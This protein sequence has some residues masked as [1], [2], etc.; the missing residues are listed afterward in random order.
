ME[1]KNLIYFVLILTVA[2]FLRF[3]LLTWNPPALNW[4][5]ISHGY[6]AYSIL[7]TGMDQWGQRLPILN[8]RAYGDYPT[9]LNIYLTIPFILIFGL[10]DFALRFPHALM[11]LLC[12]GLVYLF[13]YG[14]TKKQSVALFAAALVAIEPWYVFTSRFVLQSNLAVFFLIL[15][16]VLFIWREKN[17][18][19]LGISFLSLFLTLFAYHTTRIISPL[20]LVGALC[21]Y[22]KEIKNKLIYAASILFIILSI[23]ILINPNAT[24]RGNLLFILD[25]T[26]VNKIEQAR[27]TSKLPV[28]I[29]NL[30]YNR[31]VYFA[32]NFAKNYFSYFSP[33]FLFLDGG[34]QYQ[35][36]VPHFGLI[37]PLSLPFF[38]IG[39]I[40]LIFKSFKD[41]SI[42]YR[43][44]FRL[45]FWW[46]IISPIP[47]SLTNES[48]TVVRATAMLPIPEVLISIGFFFVLDKL[49][50]SYRVY[51]TILYIIVIIAFAANYFY[52]YFSKYRQ[53]YSWSWQYGYKQVVEY[54]KNHY[55]NYDN[56]IVTKKYGEPHEYFLYYL[57]YDPEKYLTDSTKITFF[58]SDWWWVDHFDKFWFVNDWQVKLSSSESQV[59][60]TFV[61]ESQKII[62]CKNE[63]CLLITSPGN[64]PTG[65]NRIETVNFLDGS[66]AFE[67]FNNQ[68]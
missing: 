4:D 21:I 43:N 5:E 47:A 16:G 29:R 27:N 49:P 11:G 67:I 38:Y 14:I 44:N 2:A 32:E 57:K 23:F 33:K 31:P 35:F 6:N 46:L 12:V 1:R 41:T 48:Y 10:T 60:Q 13:T 20:M 36:S 54:T 59:Q 25:Q 51:A 34:T 26:A 37:Y 8:F 63:K 15:S 56:I 66:P 42:D 61:T 39:L 22:R 7:K 53:N 50:R 62:N 19:Y 3:T 65:W 40:I 64:Y 58:K 45:L 9:T 30:I 55:N 17:R 52:N 68:I 18:Y 24:A 28:K